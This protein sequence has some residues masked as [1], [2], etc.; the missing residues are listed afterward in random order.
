MNLSIH[1]NIKIYSKKW[2]DTLTYEIELKIPVKKQNK[3]KTFWCL[4]IS[5]VKYGWKKWQWPEILNNQYEM[6]LRKLSVKLVF[7]F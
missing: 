7:G 3:N 5:Y 2:L 6:E 1:K 4:K